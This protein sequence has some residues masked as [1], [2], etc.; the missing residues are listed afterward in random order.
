MKLKTK[1][2]TCLNLHT[3]L[4][5]WLRNAKRQQIY[6]RCTVAASRSRLKRGGDFREKGWYLENCRHIK[7]K[8]GALSAVSKIKLYLKNV[9]KMQL[10]SYSRRN[11]GLKLKCSSSQGKCQLIMNKFKS[12]GRLRL[13]FIFY[14][15]V[16]PTSPKVT[17]C[18]ISQFP[19]KRLE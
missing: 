1:T 9:G 19:S 3:Y 13:V 7:K 5:W 17:K 2:L 18:C 12:R 16:S 11:M 6:T 10:L 14:W 15:T 8:V 4:S